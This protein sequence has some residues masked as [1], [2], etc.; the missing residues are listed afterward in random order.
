MHDLSKCSQANK[1]L[2]ENEAVLTKTIK[3]LKTQVHDYDVTVIRKEKDITFYLGQINEVKKK[4]ASL[5]VDH[6]T[7]NHK[8][9]SYVSSSSIMNQIV[10]P[11]TR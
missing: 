3:D 6:E 11:Q 7:L 2:K 8:L 9:N 1:V 10:C 5:Q 4:L